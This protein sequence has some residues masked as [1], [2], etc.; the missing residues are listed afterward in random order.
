M[1]STNETTFPYLLVSMA[2]GIIAAILLVPRSGPMTLQYILKEGRGKMDSFFNQ[3]IKLRD[4]VY[5]VRKKG[6]QFISRN[7]NTVE[8][9]SEADKQAY[10]EQKRNY[11]GG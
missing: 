4:N 7:H 5:T 6:K 9:A 11:L 10:E 8:I 2:L 3:V 1:K